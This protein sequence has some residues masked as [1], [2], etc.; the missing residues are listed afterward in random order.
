LLINN[1]RLMGKW[2]NSP[3][4]NAIAWAT[5]VIVGALTLISTAQIVFP[6]LGS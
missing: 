6:S 2:T 1:K 4:F 3:L 5:V